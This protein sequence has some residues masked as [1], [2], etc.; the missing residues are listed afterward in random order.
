M[1]PVFLHLLI[2]MVV[3]WT[4]A[5]VLRLI[6]IPI[7]MSELVIGVILGPAVFGWVQPSEIITVL[8]EMGIFFI[9]LHAGVKT[10]ATKFFDAA[11]HAIGVAVVGAV[12][13]F[14]A[15]LGVALWFGLSIPQ[16][17][18]VG[19]TMT[20]TAV[21]ITITVLEELKMLQTDIARV[22][23]AA[24]VVDD[25]LTLVF[26][27]LVLGIV[28]GEGAD[29]L[30]LALTLGKAIAFLGVVIAFGHWVYPKLREPFKDRHGKVFTFLLILA[31]GFG[32]IAQAM[33]LHIIIGAY[34]A[35]LFFTRKVAMPDIF[36]KVEDRLHAISYSF[37]GPIFFISLGLHVTFDAITGAGLWF[38][39]ALTGTLIIAQVAS[40]GGMARLLKM[41]WLESLS[42]GV[43]MC[44]RAE[45]AFVLMSLGLSLGVLDANVFS[46]LVFSA[47]LLNL[48]TPVGLLACTAPLR[49]G[50]KREKKNPR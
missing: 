7:I 15:S 39:L 42:V 21:V 31:L 41:S 48:F 44:G 12:V 40:A 4:A 35:G 16:A 50:Q 29:P 8:A 13:P 43:G 10:D 36:N 18:F 11:K 6:G 46:I 9:M 24:C 23:I 1:E 5:M 37:L 49:R 19:L 26:L 30:S 28:N 34:M 45:M 33:G 22:V 14:T 47:F 20:A 27:G 2:L 32:L 38:V 17:V 25:L 3:A